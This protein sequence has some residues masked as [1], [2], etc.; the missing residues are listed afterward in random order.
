M[1]LP[2]LISYVIVAYIVFAVLSNEAGHLTKTLERDA[3]VYAVYN[4]YAERTCCPYIC[5]LA[6]SWQGILHYVLPH[7]EPACS[8]QAS[9]P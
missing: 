5:L 9:L 6:Y 8:T 2:Q 1:L 4:V 3:V 7:N